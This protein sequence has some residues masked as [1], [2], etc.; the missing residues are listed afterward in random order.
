MIFCGP[1]FVGL[2]SARMAEAFGLPP[3]H[4]HAAFFERFVI[5]IPVSPTWEAELYSRDL[6]VAPPAVIT[7][8]P[9]ALLPGP[10]AEPTVR[11]PSRDFTVPDEVVTR[12]AQSLAVYRREVEWP[13]SNPVIVH[14]LCEAYALYLER[15][16]TRHTPEVWRGG[17]FEAL[18]SRARSHDIVRARWGP[19]FFAV[20]SVV[21]DVG[22]RKLVAR[23]GVPATA[24]PERVDAALPRGLPGTWVFVPKTR[25]LE[26]LPAI[27]ADFQGYQD[28]ISRLKPIAGVPALPEPPPPPSPSSSSGEE[29]AAEASREGAEG[30]YRRQPGHEEEVGS[31]IRLEQDVGPSPQSPPSGPESESYPSISPLSSPGVPPAAAGPSGVSQPFRPMNVIPHPKSYP[32]PS[33]LNAPYRFPNSEM[34]RVK[35]LPA[36]ATIEDRNCA[37]EDG[38][39]ARLG[40]ITPTVPPEQGVQKLAAHGSH[41]DIIGAAVLPSGRSTAGLRAQALPTPT[42]VTPPKMYE[43]MGPRRPFRPFPTPPGPPPPDRHRPPSPTPEPEGPPPATTREED[44]AIAAG[45]HEAEDPLPPCNHDRIPVLTPEGYISPDTVEKLCPHA[46]AYLAGLRLR[47]PVGLGNAH[48]QALPHAVGVKVFK[49]SIFEEQGP[50]IPNYP[51]CDPVPSRPL[52]ERYTVEVRNRFSALAHEEDCL[53]DV[54]ESVA[55]SAARKIRPKQPPTRKRTLT[56]KPDDRNERAA[57]TISSRAAEQVEARMGERTLEQRARDGNNGLRRIKEFL[58]KNRNNT[59]TLCKY[60]MFRHPTGI[61]RVMLKEMLPWLTNPYDAIELGPMPWL[62]ACAFNCIPTDIAAHGFLSSAGSTSGITAS[63]PDSSWVR[64]LVCDGDVEANPGP[65]SAPLSM[66]EVKAMTPRSTWAKEGEKAYATEVDSAFAYAQTYGRP[67][68]QANA[69][70]N[71]II[72]VDCD[73]VGIDGSATQPIRAQPWTTTLYPT[74]TWRRYS[75]PRWNLLLEMGDGALPS[76]VYHVGIQNREVPEGMACARM[77]EDTEDGRDEGYNLGPGGVFVPTQ[78]ITSW[79]TPSAKRNSRFVRIHLRPLDGVGVPRCTY[80]VRRPAVAMLDEHRVIQGWH[81]SGN[82]FNA[83]FLNV[84]DSIPPDHRIG[85]SPIP[86]LNNVHGRRMG[87]VMDILGNGADASLTFREWGPPYTAANQ[88]FTDGTP[89]KETDLLN[90]VKATYKEFQSIAAK[91]DITYTGYNRSD[92]QR[93]ALSVP[94]TAMSM[95]LPAMKL[96]LYSW[97][98]QYGVSSSVRDCLV[99]CQTQVHEPKVVVEPT[100]AIVRLVNAS[101][102]ADEDCGGMDNPAFPFMRG[103]REGRLSF[104]LTRDTAPPEAKLVYIPDPILSTG[105]PLMLA[106]YLALYAPWP[107]GNLSLLL[108]TKEVGESRADAKGQIFSW[109]GT[110][111]ALPGELEMA[112]VLPITVPGKAREWAGGLPPVVVTPRFGSKPVRH[113]ISRTAIAINHKPDAALHWVP[114]V[115]FVLSW[116]AD[117]TPDHTRQLCQLMEQAGMWDNVHRWWSDGLVGFATHSGVMEMRH[118][119]PGRLESIAMASGRPDRVSDAEPVPPYFKAWRESGDRMAHIP[120]HKEWTDW[121]PTV[122]WNLP[123]V[124]VGQTSF[125]ALGFYQYESISSGDVRNAPL[126]GGRFDQA[127]IFVAAE[128]R[129]CA[130]SLIHTDIKIPVASLK[131]IASSNPCGGESRLYTRIFGNSARDLRSMASLPVSYLERCSS[132]PILKGATGRN[133]LAY[134]LPPKL[135]E[136]QVVNP[137]TCISYDRVLPALKPDAVLYTWLSSVP[138]ETAPF[139]VTARGEVGTS[140]LE[141]VTRHRLMPPPGFDGP[142]FTDTD[143]TP[144]VDYYDIPEL[145]ESEFW[146]YR[147]MHF[148]K[149]YQLR[150]YMTGE[151][152]LGAPPP[153]ECPVSPVRALDSW[154]LPETDSQPIVPTYPRISTMW[155]ATM[156]VGSRNRIALLAPSD[157]STWKCIISTGSRAHSGGFFFNS[158]HPDQIWWDISRKDQVHLA[159]K[160]AM[161]GNDLGGTTVAKQPTSSSVV[162]PKSAE[163]ALVPKTEEGAGQEDLST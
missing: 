135:W 82:G 112:V 89:L 19:Q 137:E 38:D 78:A 58:A 148:V 10:A 102:L 129:A 8:K 35:P 69:Y 36:N 37:L 76:H 34:Q 18:L 61:L 133:Y 15:R 153:G 103:H 142:Y 48:A 154:Q 22:H 20:W 108:Q 97:W 64:D 111:L 43:S 73:A 86:G 74:T 134:Q 144:Q 106:L 93:M 161:W 28:F 53:N 23:G 136:G 107:C 138:R 25:V 17:H 105:D 41:T 39:V 88:C 113:W 122:T 47:H 147:L 127:A 21:L 59:D 98:G 33:D 115:D 12:G 14:K 11:G 55:V 121:Q 63:S 60:V 68:T 56:S 9:E 67:I 72:G 52:Q 24:P 70:V 101:G 87:Y 91:P 83:E 30:G 151:I 140:A 116:V 156:E 29:E 125:I 4:P 146:L 51:D 157:G 100:S 131:L 26:L 3:D 119:G 130:W 49:A 7:V 31:F 5:P 81:M 96:G 46:R 118:A 143:A 159:R 32:L 128:R 117:F 65:V 16:K 158:R 71:Q 132:A 75:S 2:V 95:V 139:V 110:T 45:W 57:R 149:G 152:L 150:D 94:P 80:G 114:L 40:V 50:N 163:S 27:F 79:S 42:T 90:T 126:P 104:H 84:P 160:E 155:W 66:D 92:I 162:S 77:V 99:T 109:F 62:A 1:T 85:F 6:F 124:D 141:P 13:L 54:E 145:S 120:Y 123:G 44:F